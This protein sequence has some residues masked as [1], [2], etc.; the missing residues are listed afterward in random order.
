[1]DLSSTTPNAEYRATVV[2]HPLS[3]HFLGH[4]VP[5]IRRFSLEDKANN[6]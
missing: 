1:M 3:P 6:G 4:E 5:Q 2:P